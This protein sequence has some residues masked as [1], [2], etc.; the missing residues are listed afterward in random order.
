MKILGS[1]MFIIEAIVV[2]LTIPVSINAGFSSKEVY[3]SVGGLMVMCIL[4][5]GAMRRDRSTAVRVGI[6]VQVIICLKA[7]SMPA[8]MFPG[9]IFWAVLIYAIYASGKVDA[10]KSVK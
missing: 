10:A 9:L 7:L 1:S 8:L 5:A 3:L 4:A 2:G 6:F